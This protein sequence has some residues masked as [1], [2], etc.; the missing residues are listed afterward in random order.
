[1]TKNR[2]YAVIMLTCLVACSPDP[3][4]V[5]P[6][7]QSTMPSATATV[8]APTALSA[9]EL[10]DMHCVRCHLAPN[11]EDLSKENWP[12]A[13]A[14]MG[15]YLGFKGDELSDF[16]LA[17]FDPDAADDSTAAEADYRFFIKLVDTEGAERLVW[18]FK[19]FVPPE[20]LIS[21]ADWQKIR[22]YYV[23]NAAPMADMYIQRPKPPRLTGFTPTEP[24][25]DIEPNGLAFTTVVDEERRQLY[26]GRAVM[27]DWVIGGR[28]GFEGTDDLLA[29]DLVTGERVGYL[30]L[31]TDP[32][33][34]ELTE[35]G[36]RVS[37]HGEHPIERGKGQGSVTDV[38]G[39]N[40][41][42]SRV[43]MLLK[44]LHRVTMHRTH[45]MD[46]DGLVDIVVNSFGDGILSN[47]GGRL[48]LYWQTP[49]YTSLWEDAAAEIP[50]GPLEG[51][52]EEN[53]LLDRVGMISSAIGDFNDDGRPDLVAL[54]AQ[55]LQQLSLFVNQGDRSFDQHVI[56]QYTPAWG[57][58]MVYAADMDGDGLTDIVAVNGDN[59]GGNSTGH[60]YTG[61]KPKPYHGLRIFRN[62]GDLT[63]T[64]RYFYPMHGALRAVIED[65][66]G[67]GDQ[68]AAMIAMWADWSFD[69][70]ETF[71][72]LE[73]QGGFE[74]SPA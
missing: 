64:Q 25:L 61:A 19:D 71:V 13:L 53:V 57:L 30:E 70:P 7:S 29:L 43:R 1:M 34:L 35:T 24:E 42:E 16:T 28:P 63:F 54:K 50:P 56:E 18:G 8:E 58:N 48:V 20:P 5:V 49:E 15:M 60:P 72:Y 21:A 4:P 14:G 11:P 36:I 68:D 74:F 41:G 39:L 55:G 23:A 62:N 45:D 26:V 69:E 2:L 31:P 9:T 59:T 66:D 51:A 38:A 37:T 46:G 3:E 6:S 65:F 10:I 22:D 33:E 27:D 52:L 44:G 17:S 12:L 73:N 67:D 47:Y 32:I 40:K